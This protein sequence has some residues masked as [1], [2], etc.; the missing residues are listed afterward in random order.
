MISRAAARTARADSVHPAGTFAVGVALVLLVA[1][2]TVGGTT[3]ALALAAAVLLAA[4]MAAGPERLGTGLVL[5]GIG[6]APM[7]SLRP[8]GGSIT[9]SDLMLALGFLLLLPVILSRRSHVPAPFLA[10]A[11]LLLVSAVVSSLLSDAP[12]GSLAVMLRLVIAAMLMPL[13]FLLWRPGRRLVPMLAWSYVGG[14]VLNT[15]IAL[16][17]GA[18]GGGNR[19]SGLTVHPNA[20]ALSGLMAATLCLYLWHASAHRWLVLLAGGVAAWSILLSGSRGTLLALV[21]IALLH[22]L[23]ERSTA[24]A[25][26]IVGAAVL[27]IPALGLVAAALGEHGTALTRLLDRGEQEAGSD[28]KRITELQEA[29][30]RFASAPVFGHGFDATT[31]LPH[32]IYLEVAIAVGVVGLAAWL[33]MLSPFV[34]VL[35]SDSVDRRL[36]YTGLAYLAYGMTQPTLWERNLWAALCLALVATASIDSRERSPEAAR[37]PRNDVRGALGMRTL[38]E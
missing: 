10:G 20:L 17:E 5:L 15:V 29:V 18:D 38:R 7:N 12:A 32:N 6:L 27:T 33:V 34:G 2:S 28:T 37:A 8:I 21:L 23:V 31:L 3:A 11:V 9:V 19:Y 30:E 25:L 16:A 4:L 26:T 13:L 22:P 14:Q 24:S 35:F 36:G 1:V